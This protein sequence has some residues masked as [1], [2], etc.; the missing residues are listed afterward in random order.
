MIIHDRAV[1]DIQL[2]VAMTV[3]GKLQ[4]GDQLH[5]ATESNWIR[6]RKMFLLGSLLSVWLCSRRHCSF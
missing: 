1:D 4:I 6:H 5:E 3:D 2:S